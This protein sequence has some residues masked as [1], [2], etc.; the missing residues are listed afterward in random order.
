[1]G[2]WRELSGFLKKK[3]WGRGRKESADDKGE[4]PQNKGTKREEGMV[5]WQLQSEEHP[6]V[7]ELIGKE[8]AI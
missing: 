1:M 5:L 7:Y 3:E 2:G 4:G 6:P 8:E